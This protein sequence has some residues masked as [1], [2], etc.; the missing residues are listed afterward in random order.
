MNAG[1]ASALVVLPEGFTE[2]VIEERPAT[3]F[4]AYDVYDWDRVGFVSRGTDAER[5]GVLFD[6]SLPGN[7]NTGHVYGADLP[8]ADKIAL[9]EYLK[10]F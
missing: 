9:L 2:A 8:T 6:T 3:F 1:E 4:R 7:A 10:T 5:Q